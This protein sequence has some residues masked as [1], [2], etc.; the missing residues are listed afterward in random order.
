MRL[1]PFPSASWLLVCLI[2]APQLAAA[3]AASPQSDRQAI[4]AMLDSLIATGEPSHTSHD[5]GE[6]L[7]H[8]VDEAIARGDAEIEALAIRAA[9][10][11]RAWLTPPVSSTRDLPSISFDTAAVLRV[12]RALS[13]S[14]RVFASVDGGEFVFVRAVRSGKREG[15]RI[16]ALL[17]KSATLPGFHVLRVKAEL[18][19]RAAAGAA[20][21]TETHALRP[22]TYAVYDAAAEADAPLRAL[23][24]GPVSTPVRELDPLLGDEPFAVWLNAILSARR[25]DADPAPDW[26]SR[27]CDE[28][29]SEAGSRLAPTAICSVVYF[30]ARGGIGQIW[31]RTADIGETPR[32]IEWVRAAP[33]RFEGMVIQHSAPDSRMLSGLPALLDT[34]PE[35]RPTGDVS[36]LPGDIIVSQPAPQAGGLADV[37]VTVRNGGQ[38]DLH[39]ALIY[40]TWGVSATERGITRQFVVD[41]PAQ[42]STVLRLQARFPNGYGFV[43]AL[44]TQLGEHAPQDA[45]APDPTPHDTCA[46]RVVNARL[47]PARYAESLLQAA[48]GCSGK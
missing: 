42:G 31:F 27:Y 44:G 32:G 6:Q 20:P 23:V 35:S 28:R 39:K 46:F 48:G 24:Y 17:P 3:Q 5:E 26:M 2:G 7:Q 30:Q 33:P 40:V 25:E 29:T 36:I 11:L 19:F 45:W 21:W 1:F 47:A 16:D 10:P 13:Y 41:I 12:R 9:S 37:T 18:T 4:M 43:M 15:G 22:L 38:G 8:G 34:A 14:A